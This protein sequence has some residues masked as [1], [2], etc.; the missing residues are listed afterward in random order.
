[1]VLKRNVSLSAATRSREKGELGQHH[2][3]SHTTELSRVLKR[4]TTVI[5]PHARTS[6]LRGCGSGVLDR[7][8]LPMS[9]VRVPRPAERDRVARDGNF[10]LG[11]SWP[12]FRIRSRSDPRSRT[13]FSNATH[14]GPFITDELPSER[15]HGK[16]PSPRFGAL[17]PT[18]EPPLSPNPKTSIY[19]PPKSLKT[20]QINPAPHST[21]RF[22]IL[23][24][25]ARTEAQ[26][27]LSNPLWLCTVRSTV[28]I[29]S[30][31]R[32]KELARRI[33]AGGSRAA[34]CRLG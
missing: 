34:D 23:R 20:R 6:G 11:I 12:W 19:H 14:I 17:N 26:T 21:L 10:D 33:E 2:M 5:V 18:P 1:V 27:R 4:L 25:T 3:R 8:L 32:P 28:K 30:S 22:N 13:A 24:R 29:T 7:A 31:T 9:R 16:G 15:L